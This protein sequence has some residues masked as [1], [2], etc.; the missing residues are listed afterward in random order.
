MSLSISH[1]GSAVHITCGGELD[2]AR[3][4]KL[5]QVV[6]MCLEGGPSGLR[7][8]ASGISLLTT[9]EKDVLLHVA[10]RCEQLGVELQLSVGERPGASSM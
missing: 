7:L 4:R 10:R 3:A 1:Q 6:E 9:P 8:D 2:P 5:E